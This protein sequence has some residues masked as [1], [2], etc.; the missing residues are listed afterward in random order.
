VAQIVADVDRI[1]LQGQVAEGEYQRQHERSDAGNHEE[2]QEV[3][4]L[5]RHLPG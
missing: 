5:L 4:Q 2:I 3:V 1:T